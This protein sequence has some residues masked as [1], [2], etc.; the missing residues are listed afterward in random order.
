[1]YKVMQHVCLRMC[2]CLCV[3]EIEAETETEIQYIREAHVTPVQ[4]FNVSHL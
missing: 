2:V 4:F 3:C 1:M